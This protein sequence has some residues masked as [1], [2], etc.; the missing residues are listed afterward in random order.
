ME[1]RI[2]ARPWKPQDLID[3]LQELIDEEP[4][5]YLNGRRTTLCMAK[6]F[7]E[8]HFAEQKWIPVTE[9]LPEDD[10]RVLALHDDGIVRIGISKGYFP[11]VV[12]RNNGKP[13]GITD[14]THWMPLPSP[15][16]GE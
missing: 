4:D 11:A 7:L 1:A 13:F 5:N 9:R 16:E 8:E 10:V 12:G 15:P 6:G 3:E 2:E 14:V